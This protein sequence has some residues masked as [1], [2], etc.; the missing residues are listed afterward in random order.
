MADNEKV[1]TAPLAV[2]K[3]NGV[4]IGKMKNI[5]VTESIQRGTVQGIGALVNSE[6]PALKWD[7]TL[8]CGFYTITFNKQN[9]LFK[10]AILRNVNTVQEFVDTILLQEDGVTIDI[11]KKIKDYKNADGI[12]V[13]KY[14]IFASVVGCFP[15]KESFDI[16][17]GQISGRDVDFQYLNPI[18]FTT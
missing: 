12:I 16:S 7:G 1:M 14:E 11:L 18:L 15:N 3:V 13:P 17:E 2:I 9:E 8:N 5:R 4:A 6:I 10:S